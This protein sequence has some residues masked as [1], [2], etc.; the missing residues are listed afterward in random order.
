MRVRSGSA[1]ATLRSRLSISVYLEPIWWSGSTAQGYLALG[2]QSR[3]CF[4]QAGSI[5]LAT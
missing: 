2:A 1:R 3:V 5:E 4:G